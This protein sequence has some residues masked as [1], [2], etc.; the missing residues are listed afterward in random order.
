[1]GRILILPHAPVCPKAERPLVDN[2]SLPLNYMS[3][4]SIMAL[5]VDR[6]ADARTILEKERLEL[7]DSPRGTKVTVKDAGHLR[8]IL[9]LLKG[10]G[11]DAAF[12][13]VAAQIYQG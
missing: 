4:H 7:V 8:I 11:I 6:L 1:M 13:D 3:D 2:S 5:R 12:T 10:H 9:T